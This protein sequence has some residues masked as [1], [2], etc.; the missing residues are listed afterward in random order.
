[1]ISLMFAPRIGRPSKNLGRRKIGCARRRA[2][3]FC[4]KI[5]SDFA[6]ASCSQESQL[7]SLSWQ[8]ALLLPFWVRQNSSPAQSIGTHWLRKSV[9]RKFRRWRSRSALTASSVVGPSEPQFQELLLFSPSRFPS[10]FASLCF[11]L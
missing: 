4:V 10:P 7:I 2:N 1:M 6:R 11:S 5:S 3:S 8:Y 9:A